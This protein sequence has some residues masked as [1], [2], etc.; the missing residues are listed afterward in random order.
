LI[1]VLTGTRREWGNALFY[2]QCCPFSL[3]P[4]K[5]PLL[6]LFGVWNQNADA[7]GWQV[8]LANAYPAKEVDITRD[9]VGTSEA[10]MGSADLT[11][12]SYVG[13]VSYALTVNQQTLILPNLVLRYTKVEQDGNR[14]PV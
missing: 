11:M 1:I 10:G 2:F 14:K 13:V 4:F 8:K 5:T 6:G 7:L 12:E 3:V 9:I